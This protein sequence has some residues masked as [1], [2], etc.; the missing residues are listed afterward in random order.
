MLRT[1]KH[2]YTFMDYLAPFEAM[3]LRR[4]LEAE[5]PVSYS[6]YPLITYLTSYIITNI[7]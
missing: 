1:Y 7:I 4:K 3:F 2:A 5:L 6:Q